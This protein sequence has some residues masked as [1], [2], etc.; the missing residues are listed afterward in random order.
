M[1]CVTR[2]DVLRFASHLPLAVI[3]R[4][5]GAPAI[6]LLRADRFRAVGALTFR[7]DGALVLT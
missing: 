4:A 2:G 1:F 7:A 5:L 6:A 3:F